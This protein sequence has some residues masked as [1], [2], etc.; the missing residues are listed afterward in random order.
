MKDRVMKGLTRIFGFSWVL[1]VLFTAE[2]CRADD[3]FLASVGNNLAMADVNNSSEA[4]LNLDKT[5]TADT[6]RD[7]KESD[8][9]YPSKRN[10]EN[11]EY[12][13]ADVSGSPAETA[14][15][16]GNSRGLKENS[17]SP[18]ERYL[19]IVTAG[20]SFGLVLIAAGIA[21]WWRRRSIRRY[22]LFP[23]LQDDGEPAA[24]GVSSPDPLIAKKQAETLPEEEINKH[25][26]R[27][28]A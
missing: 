9:N 22:W 6:P 3:V 28:A 18:F 27:R 26:Q 21:Q 24:P 14:A 12:S 19:L 2:I 4:G 10:A 1:W 13:Y 11:N 16:A 5:W 23:M 17:D 7:R 25:A 20:V 15:R 8:V